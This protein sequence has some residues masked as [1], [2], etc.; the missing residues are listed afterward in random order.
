MVSCQ[1]RDAIFERRGL[2]RRRILPLSFFQY[3]DP[4]TSVPAAVTRAISAA[5]AIGPSPSAL[6][7]LDKGCRRRNKFNWTTRT[8][9]ALS[10]FDT[11]AGL[12][13]LIRYLVFNAND[14]VWELGE[15]NCNSI[16]PATAVHDDGED[17]L[18]A[19]E[20]FCRQ[21][22]ARAWLRSVKEGA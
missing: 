5:L 19:V 2:V 22:L 9:S 15:E 7:I 16:H 21:E 11:S 20:G 14:S 8:P 18:P 12:W 17:R 4:S 10:E 3:L 13:T 6:Q 1:L